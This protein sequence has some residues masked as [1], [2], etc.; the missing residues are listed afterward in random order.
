MA[1]IKCSECKKEV[2]DKAKT[3]PNC[4]SPISQLKEITEKEINSLNLTKADISWYNYYG[5]EIELEN[6]KK[7]K[8]TSAL[9]IGLGLIFVFVLLF[10]YFEYKQ[11]DKP[12]VARSFLE[13]FVL[14]IVLGPIVLWIFYM[15]TVNG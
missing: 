12:R 1:L 7:F 11:K 10:P 3:C 14:Y 5:G 4:G 6:I 9:Y 8:K 15:L 2:S 13:I